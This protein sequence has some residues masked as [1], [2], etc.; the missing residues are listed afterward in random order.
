MSN[1]VI[2]IIVIVLVMLWCRGRSG[3]SGEYVVSDRCGVD[4]IEL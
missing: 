4:E 3:K 2:I 1:I